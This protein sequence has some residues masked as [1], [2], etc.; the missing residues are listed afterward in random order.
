M[1]TDTRHAGLTADER[2]TIRSTVL[3]ARETIEN[4][5]YRQ[6]ERYGVYDDERV[7]IDA[8]DHLDAYD[9]QTRSQI[10][11]ALDRELEATDDDYARSI[12]NY[13]REATKT[14]LNRLVALKAIEVRG[15]VTETMIKRPEYGNRS[16]MHRTVDEVAGE[17]TD[18]SD[19]G[20]GVA[21][22]LAFTELTDEIGVIFEESE[23]TAID[24][25]FT[26]R[27]EIIEQLSSISKSVW[28]SDEAMGWVYQYFGEKERE[29]IDVRISE[30]NY[31]VQDTDVATKTQL[32]TP[33]HIVEWM[34]DNSL[35][36]LWLEMHN[37]K[38][39]IDDEDKCFYL[40]PL[41]ES[42][43]DRDVKDVRDIK[44]LDPA[45]GS[46]HMLFYAFD[47]LYEMYLEQGDVAE[48][49]IPREIL[50]NNLYGIDIDPGAAQL[51]ALA[52]YVKAKNTEPDVELEGINIVSADAVLVNGE[53]KKE[54]LSRTN[55]DLERRV[56]E[57]VWT[58]FE[59]IRE[60]GS[61][62]Q[63]EER[64]EEIIKEEFEDV[65]ATGQTK[66]TNDG[67][68]KQ[69]S[70]V[71]Y[72]GEEESWQKVKGRLMNQVSEL[73]NEALERND[74]I[75]E[76]FADDVEKSVHLLDIFV[77]DYDVVISNPP[78]LSSSKMGDS[79]KK[80][81]K[82]NYIGSRDLYSAFI[83]RCGEFTQKNG[84]V[85][86]ITMDT[87][88]YLYSFR[89]LRPFLLE[90]MNFTDVSHL[91]NRE[92]GYM[93]VCFSM[94]QSP[95]ENH[96]KTRFTRL[97]NENNKQKSLNNVVNNY[98]KNKSH[99]NSYVVDQQSFKEI[100]RTPFIYWFGTDVLSLFDEYDRLGD[101]ESVKKGLITGNNDLF[102]R[103]FWEIPNHLIGNRFVQYQRSGTDAPYYDIPQDFVDWENKGE[104]IRQAD[105]H[106]QF[107]NEEYCFR[108]GVTFRGFG[109]YAVARIHEENAIHDGN[110]HFVTVDDLSKNYLVGLGTSSLSRFI[111]NGINPSPKC[112][113]GD[114]KQLPI[115][116]DLNNTKK[117]NSL[118]EAAVTNRR[119]LS[120][121]REDSYDFDPETIAES[122]NKGFSELLYAE[123]IAEA[124]ILV[125][126]GII[127][128][129]IFD[130]Y[131][132]NSSTRDRIYDTVPQ[133]LALLPHIENIKQLDTVEQACYRDLPRK[134]LSEGEY[135]K[136]VSDVD[137]NKN[138]S[139]RKVCEQVDVSPYTVALIRNENGLYTSE[140]YSE[141]AARLL[142]FYIGCVMGRWETEQVD[143]K[144]DGILPLDNMFDRNIISELSVFSSVIFG[145]NSHYEIE[146][147][148]EQ[149]LNK[150]IKNYFKKEFFTEHHCNE[151]KRRGQKVPI[152]WHLGSD[153]G[154]FN[155]FIYYHSM[156]GDTFPKLRGQYIDKK[157]DTL[158][159]RLDA[160]ESEL[161]AVED[162]RARELRS[163]MEEIEA[164]IEDI[165]EFRDRVDALIDEGFEPDFESGIWENIQKVDEFDL[166]AVPMNKF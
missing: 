2:S 82:E 116:H 101:V 62:V 115:K 148:L 54:V 96:K 130:E 162:D 128:E 166:L 91:K 119:L 110:T 46:G 57:Q 151:Y 102:L 19:N 78:Y 120:C 7:D 109:K 127:D 11:A 164:E 150:N 27:E 156:D 103:K 17:L 107:P 122:Y 58:S 161:E 3:K 73:A 140:E 74:P 1:T 121:S 132:I 14:Y 13:V 149:M 117:I 84:Y 34:V 40:A 104:K 138:K 28:E 42:L 8:L 146:N 56:L 59:H 6:L 92:E 21:I 87:F 114:V 95:T 118:I 100:N 18:Q 36:R 157:L 61:L 64:I 89:K 139:L 99:E 65:T 32:F 105:G 26:V 33:R 86:M 125:V 131:D 9:K 85:S 71:S 94:R 70:V 39:D 93:N 165:S 129:L 90:E 142:S 158:Q 113:V 72:S 155:C 45:C 22:E 51:A 63:I 37:K 76:I 97:V 152:Y 75:E 77:N 52:L 159:N 154:S 5:L 12:K 47:V 83:Q 147:K 144:N 49:Y 145:Q 67:L 133:N 41:E 137:E 50:A 124:N 38:T 79:L 60:W 135:D 108:D 98:R 23:Y 30:E 163:E 69:S 112:Q 35:G 48:K 153:K 29:E 143:P 66:F 134:T 136:L 123:D 24:L 44:V 16:E 126:H 31:K 25:D 88:M 4:D 160:V 106:S 53:K 80:Y 68:A 43:I 111:I 20:F 141:V 81:V 55:S 15:L 10:D